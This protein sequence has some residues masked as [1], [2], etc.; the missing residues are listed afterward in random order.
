MG[1]L[2]VRVIQRPCVADVIGRASP[3]AVGG[4]GVRANFA[5]PNPCP[6]L[7]PVVEHRDGVG[8]DNATSS[9]VGDNNAGV[10][11]RFILGEFMEGTCPVLV[12]C[13]DPSP[14]LFQGFL[15]SLVRSRGHV[16]LGF[17]DPLCN[18]DVVSGLSRDESVPPSHCV[19]VASKGQ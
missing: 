15:V 3:V 4:S 17:G 8:K 19:K 11:L 5:M 7:A 10:L 13:G 6:F 14:E 12:R 16:S 1:R 2:A 9:E 18:G